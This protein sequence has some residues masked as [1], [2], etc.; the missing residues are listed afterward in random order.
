MIARALKGDKMADVLAW[1]ESEC[2]GFMRT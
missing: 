2:E 1:A